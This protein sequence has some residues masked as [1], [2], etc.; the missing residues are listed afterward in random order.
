[1][2]SI[3]VA[4][5]VILGAALY[6][7]FKSDDTSSAE[8]NSEDGGVLE[9][10]GDEEANIFWDAMDQMS[11]IINNWPDNSEP[12]QG[13][14]ETAASINGVPVAILA[15]LLWK[16]SRYN[17][18]IING[19]KRSP[20]GAMGIAQ[21]MPKTAREELGSEA[22]ALDPTLAIPG[23]ARYLRKMY[24]RTGAWDKALAAYNWGIGNLQ[25]KGFDA[26]PAETK[27]YY[28]VILAKAGVDGGT[29]A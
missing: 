4:A 13:I 19:T 18:A 2:R 12:Y 5:G 26:A 24:N 11:G 21:F 3:S 16:E 29:Y 14:I 28:S 1:M 15:W 6:W 7:R 23:A 27:D 20:V 25:R 17:P 9:T 8:L 22:A 10:A